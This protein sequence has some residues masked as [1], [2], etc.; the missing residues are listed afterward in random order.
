MVKRSL[1]FCLFIAL[2]PVFVV[3]QKKL[4][5]R[6]TI[7]GLQDSTLVSVVNV[8]NLQDTIAA[9]YAKAGSFLLQGSLKEPMLVNLHLF[10]GKTL[11]TFLQNEKIKV[12][13]NVQ[14]PDKLKLKGAGL[15]KDFRAF[16][17]QFDPFFQRI[18]ATNRLLQ[19][20]VNVDSSRAVLM[21][22]LDTIQQEIDVYLD[23]NKKSPVTVFLLAATL[24][25]KDD[26]LVLDQRLNRLKPAA[27][28]NMY[29]KYLQEVVAANKP[30]AIG[31]LAP[32][33]TQADTSGNL[34][35][36]SSFRGK[37]VLLDFWASWCGPC[38]YENPNV[39][40]SYQKFKEKNF[41]VLGVSLDRPGQKDKWLKAIYEDRLTWTNVSDLQYFNNVVAVQYRIEGIP[42]NFLIDPQG[43]IVAKNLR[44]PMLEQKLCEILGC[45]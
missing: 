9:T 22:L 29:G 39:V 2:L 37:Y 35:T 12:V 4:S 41:T 10:P 7:K 24:Q 11:L 28:N 32:D 36:L 38:R 19:T 31:S 6:G 17:K 18:T 27:L 40:A 13:G 15:Y 5:I 14:E 3:A 23:K 25:L 45:E 1:L 21:A 33:F 8:N 26:P 30:T 16:Q 20:G 43:K 44:G 42:Q 34:I